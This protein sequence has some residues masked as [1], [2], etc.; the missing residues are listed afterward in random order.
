MSDLDAPQVHVKAPGETRN[1]TI[2]YAQKLDSGEL[3]TG[4]PTVTGA[5]TGL[6]IANV[7]VNTVALTINGQSRVAGQAV[8]FTAAGG[9]AG[10]TYVITAKCG[11]TSTPA[12]VALEGRCTLKVL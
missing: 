2:D 7:A 9:T 6:T 11:S 1:I 8:G 10:V 12:E 5:P 4:T 3:L